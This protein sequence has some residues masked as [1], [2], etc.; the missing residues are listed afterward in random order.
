MAQIIVILQEFHGNR[1][2][3]GEFTHMCT[4][5]SPMVVYL[6]DQAHTTPLDLLK[7]LLENM[8]ND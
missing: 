3:P 8:E 6:K 2:Q 7:A 5:S 1:Y 4:E